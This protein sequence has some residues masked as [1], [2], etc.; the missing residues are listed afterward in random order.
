LKPFFSLNTQP[1]L[2]IQSSLKPA[3]RDLYK[4]QH[5]FANGEIR[6]LTKVEEQ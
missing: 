6:N 4:A 5:D 2:M 1:F 3:W